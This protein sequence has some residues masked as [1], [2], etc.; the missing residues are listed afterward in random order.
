MDDQLSSCSSQHCRLYVEGCRPTDCSIC[1][2]PWAAQYSP[3][4]TPINLLLVHRNHISRRKK[5][6]ISHVKYRNV[7]Q[8]R[9]I[10]FHTFTTFQIYC[11]VKEYFSTKFGN[12]FRNLL[13]E[14]Y[15][16]K[17]YL[18]SFRFDISIVRCLGVYFLLDTVYLFLCQL[19]V[20]RSRFLQR[21]W[22]RLLL[23]TFLCSVICLSSVCLIDSCPLLK[24]LDIYLDVIW[25][26]HW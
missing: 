8:I 4:P 16:T 9:W 5:M 3:L 1:V 21:Q 25:Q 11:A 17:F 12:P 20:R 19:F 26:I 14:I 10:I 2:C 18:A 6:R 22:F 7:A 13:G 23:Y 24:P 15:R